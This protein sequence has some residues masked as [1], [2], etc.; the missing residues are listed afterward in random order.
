MSVTF[1]ILGEK[2]TVMSPEVFVGAGIPCCR[3]V[4]NAGDFVVTFPGSYHL[5]FSHVHFCIIGFNCGEAA[6]IATPEWLRFA[7]EAAVRRASIDCPPMVSHFQLLYSL[8]LSLCTR[9]ALAA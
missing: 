1:A 4:Q 8:A 9:F 6:N 5:G 3:L 2:T 7:K